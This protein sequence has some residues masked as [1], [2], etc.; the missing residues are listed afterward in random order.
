MY[1]DALRNQ[2]KSIIHVAERINGERVYKDYP[3]DYQFY[4][5][6][7]SGL[8]TTIFNTPVSKFTTRNR[9]E[10][11]REMK[12]HGN[13]RLYE[14]DFNPVVKCLADH[15][16]NVEAP[17]LNVCF[18]DIEADFDP[19]VGFS[20]PSDP[21]AAVTAI[22]VYLTQLQELI[23]LSITPKT[24]TFE[25]GSEIGAQFPNTYI[26]KT[27]AEMLETF[28]ELIDDSDVLTGWNSEGYDIPYLVNRVTRVLNRNA[29]RKFCLWDRYPS[30]RD[31]EK[32]GGMSTTY[33]LCGRIH[34]DYLALYQKYTY[35]EMH[36]YSLD[37]VSE[38]ELGEHKVA[39][40]GSLDELYNKDYGKFLE[41][42]RQDV[43]LM[44]KM[45]EKLRYIELANE[46]AHANTVLIPTT[47]GA[48]AVT[49]QAI[50][51]EAHDMGLVVPNK[52][53]AN[54]DGSKV[55]GAYVAT[56]NKGL[57]KWIGAVDINSLYPSAIR[58]INMG[59]ETIVGQL[60][61]IMTDR[62]INSRL[63]K[64][65][66]FSAA[67]EGLFSSLEYEAVLK[68][69]H[70]VEITIDWEDG[71]SDVMTADKVYDMIFDQENKLIV[72]AN[73]TLFTFARKGIIPG[74][75][76]RWYSERKEM[77]KKMH[78]SDT[79]KDKLFWDKRQLIRKINLNSLYGALLNPYCRFFDQRLGQSTTLCGRS[80]TQHMA[81]HINH[82]IEGKYEHDGDAIIYGDTDSAYFT[83]YPALKKEI[84]NGEL[85]WDEDS[86]IELYDDI[87]DQANISFPDF[88]A[89]SFNCP[90]E[91]GSII[92]AGRE[93]AAKSA[94]FITKKRY[95]ALMFEFDGERFDIGDATGKIKAMGMDL[96]R[97]DTPVYM[98]DFLKEILE[99][100]LLGAEEDDVLTR[101]REFK[102]EFGKKQSW[103]KGTP[104][105]VNKLRAYIAKEVAQGKA[106]MPGHTRAAMN[107]N[108]LCEM[109]SDNYSIRIIDGAKTIVC[110]LRNNPLG[111]TSVAY[112]ID[113]HRLPDWFKELP[114][115][116]K[117]M[118]F[119]II[120]KKILNLLGVL[121][122]DLEA[123]TAST[124]I[125]DLFEFS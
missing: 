26:F 53:K 7:P 18:L 89:K 11:G 20:D 99:D 1:V 33:D 105:R 86:V 29:T 6:D 62:Y 111:I 60:R 93:M 49:E 52:P 71:S 47:M 113:Q 95:A 81:A 124:T 123:G 72:S 25:K 117:A 103:E 24:L 88:M 120:D 8:H 112:P 45:D 106:T 82:T 94:L 96:K 108:N 19:E 97:S 102:E 31:Y 12:A 39:Y 79:A 77:Q 23:T 40:E 41:Y 2:E 115:D 63:E 59:P 56:P 58:A 34:L 125:H 74:L 43:M 37:N 98:Q 78:E 80:I 92:V 27:E 13:V 110:K 21:L 4:Y 57:H 109:H 44:V 73:G 116:D 5:D 75:L 14:S 15:Y 3:I 16:R 104:K 100:L 87:A 54:P 28:L 84:D 76:E 42:N 35:H 119:A 48:V 122:W 121:H 114:F 91:L 9:K 55:P 67:W 64:K 32:F 69:R 36:S 107:W 51:N 65:M 30:K 83:A 50:I 90:H 66:T 70:D 61:P 38:Y 10:F 68:R 118:E 46:L 17:E 85:K 101:V 22:S